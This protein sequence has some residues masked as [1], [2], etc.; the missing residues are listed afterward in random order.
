MKYIAVVGCQFS[1]D[2]G[3][4]TVIPGFPSLFCN[5]DSKGIY[6]GSLSVSITGYNGGGVSNGTGSGVMIP[7]SLCCKVDNETVLREGDKSVSI[8]VVEI[9]PPIHKTNV[10][11]TISTANQIAVQCD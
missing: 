4:G 9:G 2:S 3:A 11:L 6:K 10:I 7:T 8:E 1:F 5:I